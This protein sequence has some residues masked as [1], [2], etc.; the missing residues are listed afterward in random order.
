MVGSRSLG[1][2]PL[3]LKMSARSLGLRG[4]ASVASV[5]A[6]LVIVLE[7]C[8]EAVSLSEALTSEHLNWALEI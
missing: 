3:K 4:L 8:G 1:A 2:T 6:A 7:V 5:M